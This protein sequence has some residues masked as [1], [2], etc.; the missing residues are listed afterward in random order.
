MSVLA[1]FGWLVE[2]AFSVLRALWYVSVPALAVG[3]GA[4]IGLYR[5]RPLRT[6]AWISLGSAAAGP[7]IVLALASLFRADPAR[8]WALGGFV[9]LALGLSVLTV[10]V[11]CVAGAKA[12]RTALVCLALA[13][14]LPLPMATFLAVMAMSG[15]WL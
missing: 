11:A 14:L 3:V 15:D 12:H 10:Q 13:S 2:E 1:Y 5:H 7:F 8:P 6:P 9:A 4:C